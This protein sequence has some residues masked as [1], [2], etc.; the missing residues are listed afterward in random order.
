MYTGTSWWVIHHIISN[1]AA[2]DFTDFLFPAPDVVPC[3]SLPPHFIN[4]QRPMWP[5]NLVLF[6]F[7]PLSDLEFSESWAPRRCVLHNTQPTSLFIAEA[8]KHSLNERM[9]E[10]T[11]QHQLFPTTDLPGWFI[12]LISIFLFQIHS[13]FLP[14]KGFCGSLF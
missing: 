11:D 14:K 10:G 8:N 13:S 12:F 2:T 3:S 7:P 5:F 4:Q 6:V 1:S 9:R